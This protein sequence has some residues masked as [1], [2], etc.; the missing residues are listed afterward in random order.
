MS[1]RRSWPRWLAPAWVLVALLGLVRVALGA[2]PLPPTPTSHVT[3]EAGVLSPEA[4]ESLARRLVAYESDSGH[5]IVVWIGRTTGG[6]PIEE[7]AVEAF[8]QWK[9]GR[10]DLD[11]GLALFVMVEDRALRVEVGYGLEPTVTDLLASRVIRSIMLPRIEEGDWDAAIVG[12]VE[13]LVDTIEGKPASLPADPGGPEAG[14]PVKKFNVWKSAALI[15]GI[16]VFL[17]LL[18]TNPRLALGLLVLI[19][20]GLGRGRDGGFGGGFGGM[21]GSSGGGGATGR[22]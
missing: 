4:R 11:D 20:H 2:P 8:E 3:D 21:G 14:R 7:F 18:V 6:V 9:I 13:A 16:V 15:I 19:G 17:I 12:G 22:W 10:S 5:Q 1:D